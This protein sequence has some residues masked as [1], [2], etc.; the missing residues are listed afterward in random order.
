M[1]TQASG[2]GLPV[3]QYPTHDGC[4][5]SGSGVRVPASGEGSGPP[6]LMPF[7][8]RSCLNLNRATMAWDFSLLIVATTARHRDWRARC[9]NCQWAVKF[10]RAIRCR[11]LADGC[12][13]YRFQRFLFFRTLLTG[14][15]LWSNSETSYSEPKHTLYGRGQ[16]S[17]INCAAA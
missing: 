8:F 11:D 12:T 17:A 15:C 5:H 9:W 4:P 13:S 2:G 6:G 1:Q 14:A 3:H 16:Y 7:P 10:R